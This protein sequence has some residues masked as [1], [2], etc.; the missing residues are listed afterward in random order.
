MACPQSCI[1]VAWCVQRIKNHPWYPGA[2]ASEYG[3][4]YPPKAVPHARQKGYVQQRNTQHIDSA[5][6]DA[7]TTSRTDYQVF[8]TR[9]C[10]RSL[11]YAFGTGTL[12]LMLTSNTHKCLCELNSRSKACYWKLSQPMHKHCCG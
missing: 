4:Q 11:L 6:F 5:P 2:L 10:S 3:V 8:E 9:L 7:A 12:L 1:H